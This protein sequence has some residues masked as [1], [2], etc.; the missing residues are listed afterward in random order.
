MAQ[1]DAMNPNY[2]HW[3]ITLKNAGVQNRSIKEQ[4]A[5]ECALLTLVVW[6]LFAG[7]KFVVGPEAALW[8][9]YC[10]IRPHLSPPGVP[11]NPTTT[12]VLA[13]VLETSVQEL[14]DIAVR[15]GQLYP[16]CA[17]GAPVHVYRDL[18]HTT[19]E[20]AVMTGLSMVVPNT[21]PDLVHCSLARGA[22]AATDD[23]YETMVQF[24]PNADFATVDGGT[25]AMVV[26][27]TL[28]NHINYQNFQH[29]DQHGWVHFSGG[30]PPV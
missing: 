11:L 6:A 29:M 2:R 30:R 18:N 15:Y 16:K 5:A 9:F 26:A 12:G 22:S 4:K 20:N 10:L 13:R 8:I 3:C 1:V 21:V 27:A 19:T 17:A 23:A 28:Q 24:D 25:R 7:F 14:N